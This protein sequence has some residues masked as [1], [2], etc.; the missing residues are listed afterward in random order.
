MIE[1]RQRARMLQA[2]MVAGLIVLGLI[3]KAVGDTNQT[4]GTFYEEITT[5]Q[6]HG[7]KIVSSNETVSI[8]YTR[9]DV[10]V[11]NGIA[12]TRFLQVYHNLSQS[13]QGYAFTMPLLP[14]TTITHFN[15]WDM[16]KRYVGAIEE[17]PRAE[18]V[19]KKITGDETPELRR[20][21]G[22]VR[23]SGNIYEMRVFPIQPGEDKQIELFSH[24]RL[25]MER[26][27]FMLAIPLTQLTKLRGARHGGGGSEETDVSVVLQDELPIKSVTTTGGVFSERVID[28][29][30]R[31][32]TLHMGSEPVGDIEIR[33]ELGLSGDS[34]VL[35]MTHEQDGQRFFLLRV[36]SRSPA[37]RAATPAPQAS[38]RAFYMGVWR[39]ETIRVTSDNE[40]EQVEG[41]E[42]EFLAFM[43]LA[44]LDPSD[45]FHGSYWPPHVEGSK[46]PP[47][48]FQVSVATKRRYPVSKAEEAL[49]EAFGALRLAAQDKKTEPAPVDVVQHLRDAL[50]DRNCRLVYLFLGKLPSKPL[51][52]LE[53]IARANAD[54]DFVLITKD[55][56]LPAGLSRL[57][58]VS[59]YSLQGGWRVTRPV[60]KSPTVRIIEI[61]EQSLNEITGFVGLPSA[62]LSHL[63]ER[64]PNF[65]T[66]MPTMRATGD[67]QVDDVMAFCGTNAAAVPGQLGVLW[68]SG[69]YKGS[70]SLNL[71]LR[72]PRGRFE[73]ATTTN[74]TPVN[75]RVAA[76]L[77]SAGRRSQL[78][79]A[80]HAR[81]LADNLNSR[82]A[83]L[84]EI[85][86][87]RSRVRVSSVTDAERAQKIAALRHEVARLSKAFSFISSETAFIALPPD[88][89]ERYGFTPQV[90]A[91]Q[92]YYHVEETPQIIPEPAVWQLAALG[93]GLL[94]SYF[95]LRHKWQSQPARR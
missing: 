1:G 27:Q 25:G 63:W 42:L 36:L 21:P 66:A 43:T 87:G 22:I 32:L 74:E 81:R 78:V 41:M 91:A 77:D 65:G 13:N 68:L 9:V 55:D 37:Q 12:M 67:V 34:A 84:S 30:H 80:F 39:P 51:V 8:P 71:E 7:G 28:A 2:H 58:N 46:V 14:D 35:P 89:Q 59:H 60:L 92:Q 95:W 70:G 33:Y 72:M 38:G 75:I 44:V 26:G 16:G 76:R 83:F 4:A 40:D 29:G 62:A 54:R 47:E 24:R 6:A 23:Q 15:L 52:A 64:L 31:V 5:V 17:R 50:Q 82:I 45:T 88:L 11:E 53:A 49:G 73:F 19:Y 93:L 90:Y 10:A 57:E 85:S 61:E 20:D 18:E 3:G 48:L 94:A 86:R 56:S 69:D 79:G